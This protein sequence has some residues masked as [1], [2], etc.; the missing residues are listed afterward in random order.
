MKI[1]SYPP[2][3]IFLDLLFIFLFLFILNTSG[4]VVE[5]ILPEERLFDNAKIIYYDEE[6]KSYFTLD[7]SPYVTHRRYTY[8]EECTYNIPE[9]KKHKKTFIVY[10]ALLQKEISDITLLA[11]G[12]GVCK[13][14]KFFINPD[15][16]LDYKKIL[17]D[18]Q[19]LKKIQ[20]YENLLGM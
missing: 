20:G 1:G 2:I 3:I 8:L 4:K 12:D 6:T 7:N 15:G 18:N 16:K 5:I 14:I 19:C 9:C 17:N 10:P 11:L 13:K